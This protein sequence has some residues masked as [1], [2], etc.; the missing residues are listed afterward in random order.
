MASGAVG[1]IYRQFTMSMAVSILF[2]AFLALSLTPALCA[3]LLKPIDKD[4]HENKGG[5]FGLFNNFIDRA[6]N[7]YGKT[8]GVLLRRISM[9]LVLYVAIV[10][11]L[12]YS[13]DR[14]PTSFLPTE[15]QGAFITLYT[16]PSE[17]T[18][19]RTREIVTMYEDHAHSRE[20]T[21]NV[22][23]VLGF[24]F[25]GSGPNTALSFTTLKD[26]EDRDSSAADEVAVANRTMFAAP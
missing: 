22:F 11:G 21:E 23:A 16:L 6:T 18:T 1:E 13:F 8:V 25:S 9:M 10:A 3:T 15:D 19:E 4:H 26:W 12:G 24:S 17:A 20:A 7:F 2:S 5:F 14:L